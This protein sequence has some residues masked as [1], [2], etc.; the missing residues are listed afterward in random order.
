MNRL[1][2]LLIDSFLQDIENKD[3]G[4]TARAFARYGIP[5]SVSLRVLTRPTER[6]RNATTPIVLS[7]K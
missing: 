6:R 4:A 2:A 7:R 3:V 5:I 1:A